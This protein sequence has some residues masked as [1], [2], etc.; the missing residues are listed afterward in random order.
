MHA[1]ERIRNISENTAKL[2]DKSANSLEEQLEGIRNVAG[3][4]DNLSL[5]STEIE[6]EMTKFK[7]GK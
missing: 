6:Q 5:V 1:I 3:R 7:L 4:I 2:T